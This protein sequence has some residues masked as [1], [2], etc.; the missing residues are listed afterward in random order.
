MSINKQP[1]SIVVPRIMC[2]LGITMWIKNTL[3]YTESL[4]V[5]GRLEYSLACRVEN[6]YPSTTVLVGGMVLPLVH[7]TS[8]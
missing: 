4:S 3:P 6:Q 7:T 8:C 2:V 5:I 1:V